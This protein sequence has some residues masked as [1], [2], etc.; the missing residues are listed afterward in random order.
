MNSKQVLLL[1]VAGLC[2][3]LVPIIAFVFITFAIYYS[4]WFIWTDNWLSELA[5]RAGERPIWAARGIISLLFNIGAI[6]AGI[7]GIICAIAARKI[8]KLNTSLG[9]LGTLLL[10]IDMLALCAIGIF[11]ITTGFLH[12][13]VSIT[14]FILVPLSLISIG[15]VFRSAS[16]KRIGWFITIFGVISICAFPFFLVPQPW[17]SNA[18]VEMI[19]ITSISASAIVFGVN[20]FKGDF[21]LI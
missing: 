7:M 3:V 14:F 10:F 6:I 21:D 1:K 18:I 4:P 5:G 16:E 9:R 20:L 12:D 13:V 2:G 19:P 17:G 11:P 8:S 15:T